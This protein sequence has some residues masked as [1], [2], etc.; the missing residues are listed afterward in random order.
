MDESQQ[1]LE[2]LPNTFKQ[3]TEGDYI[4]FLWEAF[5]S[6]YESGK[7]QF[8]MLAYHM[9]YMSFVFFSVWQIKT[10]RKD[11]FAM[12]LVGFSKDDEKALLDATTPFSFWTI[13]EARIFRFLKLIGCDNNDIGKFAKLVQVRNDIAH[14][15]GNIFFNDQVT[16]DRKVNEILQQVDAIQGHMR[17][18]LH[19]CMSR[20]L[21]ESHDPEN[22]EYE[23]TGDQ[24]QEV[25]INANYFS[26][27]DIE[28]CL[29]FDIDSLSDHGHFAAIK[30]LFEAFTVKYKCD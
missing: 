3:Q 16:A 7:F 5:E 14:P 13:N 10:N 9:L 23:D 28:A 11:S 21:Q 20:F 4:R 15:N 29:T 1:I 26:M 22:R 6:N 30:V 12:S 25:L 18:I 19:D 17:P 8:A 2:Y 27:K 24:V